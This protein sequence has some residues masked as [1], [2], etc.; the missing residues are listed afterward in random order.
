[1]NCFVGLMLRI[2]KEKSEVSVICDELH[3]SADL[4]KSP[5]SSYFIQLH[6]LIKTSSKHGHMDIYTHLCA[7]RHN[8]VD[9]YTHIQTSNIETYGLEAGM[10]WG[11]AWRRRTER[12]AGLPGK[13]ICTYHANSLYASLPLCCVCH[14]FTMLQAC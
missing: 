4:M 1:M 12:W 2:N 7:G 3:H 5:G 11:G 10:K 13:H 8:C 6:N 14:A 9:A